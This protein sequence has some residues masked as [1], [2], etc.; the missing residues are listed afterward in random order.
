MFSRWSRSLTSRLS[1]AS[2]SARPSGIGAKMP[3]F[4]RPSNHTLLKPG[5]GAV[6]KRW[7]IGLLLMGVLGGIWPEKAPAIERGLP[8]YGNGAQ[9]FFAGVVPPPG[10]YTSYNLVNYQANKFAGLPGILAFH[11]EAVSNVFSFAYVGD[12]KILGANYSASVAVPVTYFGP[13]MKPDAVIHDTKLTNL[14]RFIR[15]PP[16]YRYRGGGN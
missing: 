6:M 3:P 10:F 15:N 16:A 14:M 7:F 5:T 1:C 9:N 2:G 8:E 4:C 13:K 12:F 11:F